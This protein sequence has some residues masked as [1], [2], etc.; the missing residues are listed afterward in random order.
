MLLNNPSTIDFIPL[1]T[2]EINYQKTDFL[3]SRSG[4]SMIDQQPADRPSFIMTSCNT[5]I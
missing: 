1:V 3:L 4:S 2:T 5:E